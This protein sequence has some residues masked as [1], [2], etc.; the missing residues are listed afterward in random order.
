MPNPGPLNRSVIDTLPAAGERPAV[1]YRYAGDRFILLEYGEMVLDLTTNF[2]IFGLND[3]IQ[4]AG[5]EGLIETVPALRSMLIQYDSLRL[6]TRELVETLKKL[7]HTIPSVGDLNIPSRRL[8]LPMAFADRWTRSDIERYVKY[9]RQ[10]APNVI[11]GHN[12]EYIA[13]YNGLRDAE[14]VVHYLCAT[15]WWNACIGFWPGLPFMFPLDPRYAIVT[16]KY[17]PTRPWTP[18]GAVGIGGP[19]VAIYPVASPGGYQLFG[20][21]IP[22]FDLQQRN[23]AFKPSPI[24]LQPADRI[25]WVR[26]TD[27]E[28]EAIRAR[29]YDGTYR[30]KVVAYET[31]NVKAYLGFL[32]AVKDE[33]AAFQRRQAEAVKHVA[34]P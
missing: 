31:L 28:L 7:E 22:I 15:D 3:A 33:A 18:E 13:R 19:C 12:I 27:E 20:R 24:L 5:I 4:R 29:V 1:V 23:P 11:D 17:N 8:Q 6:P 21:T 26:V 10:D 30:Y 9:T 32:D 2:R 16:P 34:I 14:E 25:Q